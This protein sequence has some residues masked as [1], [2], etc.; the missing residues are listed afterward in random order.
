M[1]KGGRYLMLQAVP[2]PTD[3]PEACGVA[4]RP[5]EDWTDPFT[6][7]P[8]TPDAAHA[9]QDLWRE[10]AA[11]NAGVAAL[12]GMDGWKRAAIRAAFARP[13]GPPPF[14]T[15]AEHALDLARR[16][17]PGG[18]AIAA[19][20]TRL[21]PGFA[22]RCAAAG[23]PL[24]HVEDG[25][26][27]SV[28]LGVNFVTAGS[29]CV[30]P[31][32]PHYDPGAPSLLERIL[33][34]AEF[35]PDLLE[36]ARAFRERI[37]ALGVTKYN[38]GGR[39]PPAFAAALAASGGR[40]RILV[41]GQVED[42]ASV[43]LG[44]AGTLRNLDLLAAVRAANPAA[45]IIYRPHPDVQTGYRRGYVTRREALRHADAFLAE[46]DITSLFAQ[47]EEVHTLTSLAGFEA[48]LRGLRVT[49]HGQPFY[50]GWGL[51]TDLKPPPRRARK[52]S[53]DALV[54]GA[55]LLYPRYTDP[56]TGLP[57]PPETLLDRLGQRA[58]W[59]PL[60]TGRRLYDRLWWRPQGWLLKQARHFG[61]WQR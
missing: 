1:L 18:G 16:D 9:L 5:G 6:G 24:L 19:W 29:L 41:P 46:G 11:Q 47:V 40:R 13:G 58:D 17:G 56:V 60:P 45:W 25:F 53:L 54:A 8:M 27:R 7:R 14:A 55:L 52:L 4:I 33:A 30:D 31:H 28:G 42:D 2:A 39:P 15:T 32:A 49:T 12:L 37:V 34:T 51:T 50:A 57:C 44:G 20:A 21:P 26:L 10:R 61:L 48:L 3:P 38:L 35:P 59:P 22:A 43:R 23:V 36:R